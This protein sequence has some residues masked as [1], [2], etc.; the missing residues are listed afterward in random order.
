MH[1]I[2]NETGVPAACLSIDCF[3]IE[4]NLDALRRKIKSRIMAVVKSNG[5][6]LSLVEY[7]RLL[8]GLGIEDFAVGSCEEALALRDAGIAAPVLLLTPQVSAEAVGE[9]LRRDIM[10]T[11]GSLHQAEAARKAARDAGIQPKVHIK[12]DTGLGRYGFLPDDLQHVGT[13]VR[14]MDVRGVFTHFASPYADAKLTKK[15]YEVFLDSIR[16]LKS[17]GI[18]AEALHCCASGGMLNHPAMHMDMVRL[19]SALLGRVPNGRAHGLMPAVSLKAPVLAVKPS[20]KGLRIGYRGMV[21]TGISRRIGILPVGLACGLTPSRRAF[22][23]LQHHQYAVINNNRARVLGPLGIG[24][25]A[26]DLTGVRCVE[27]DM[28]K[29]DVNPLYCAANIQRVYENGHAIAE[30]KA[31]KNPQPAFA[32]RATAAST[33]RLRTHTV[34]NS[35]IGSGQGREPI[36]MVTDGMPR[37]SIAQSL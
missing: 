17:L 23:L 13:A 36:S 35:S 5:Y 33:F 34:A 32:Q 9:L 19:G 30:H 7:A 37:S 4:S 11:V 1:E 31:D 8:A 18:K 10:L 20:G 26:V 15:Q 6:G 22:G 25:L 3:A 29:L 24:A 14:D 12:V 16:Q 21:G 2:S 28:A 27:G